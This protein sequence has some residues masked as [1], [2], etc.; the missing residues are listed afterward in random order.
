MSENLTPPIPYGTD[1]TLEILAK[2]T[3]E[4]EHGLMRWSSNY[5]FLVSVSYEN[6]SLPAIYKPQRGERPLWDFPD[7][8]LCNRELAAYLTSEQLGWRIVPPTV[9]RDGP[10]GLG[11][12][13]C[14][15]DHDPELNYFTFDESTVPQVKRI[16]A[17]DYIVNNADRKGGHCLLDSE[18]HVWGIDHG[19]TFH[20]APKLR[21]VIW[22]FAGQPIPAAL[23][24]DM[25]RLCA[26]L[27]DPRSDYHQ[28]LDSL[29]TGREIAAFH[30]RVRHLL[31]TGTFP[32]PGPNGPNYPWPPV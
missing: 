18:G 13:Q 10:R 27:E 1:R 20:S 31:K 11:S 32:T 4:T 16:C 25:R 21:T 19:I 28:A 12:L 9:V 14:F 3:V 15:I 2:G 7:G 17:F 30:N 5:T 29:L 26:L 6:C 22:E 24:D 8:M 23:I